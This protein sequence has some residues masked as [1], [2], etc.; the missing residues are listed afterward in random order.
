MTFGMDIESKLVIEFLEVIATS[1][2]KLISLSET[3]RSH[4]TVVRVLRSFDCRYYRTGVMLEWYVDAELQNGYGM[5]WWVDVSWAETN[6]IIESKIL[7][8]RDQNQEVLKEF[9]DKFPETLKDLISQLRETILD[10]ADSKTNI[11][12]VTTN[13]V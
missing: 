12:L 11:D 6:W 7:I 3:L 9:S 1:N 5:C 8:N 2:E 13:S 10:L 4:P